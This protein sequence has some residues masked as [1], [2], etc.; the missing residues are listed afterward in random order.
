MAVTIARVA[1]NQ[2]AIGGAACG[3]SRRIEVC[4]SKK[5]FRIGQKQYRGNAPALMADRHH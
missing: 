5:A 4:A 3:V 1:V 2:T